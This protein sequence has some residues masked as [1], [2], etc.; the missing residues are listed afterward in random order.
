MTGCPTQT[1][2]LSH[3]TNTV[4]KESSPK[5]SNDENFQFFNITEHKTIKSEDLQDRIANEKIVE[6]TEE[7]TTHFGNIETYMSETQTTIEAE[8]L[9]IQ[10]LLKLEIE[11]SKQLLRILKA[12]A[13][14]KFVQPNSG[15]MLLIGKAGVSE[16]ETRLKNLERLTKAA[17]TVKKSFASQQNDFF[18]AMA[19]IREL[20]TQ[21]ES[22]KE[23][24][25]RQALKLTNK[26]F[27]ASRR[28]KIRRRREAIGLELE[29]DYLN[30]FE[31]RC[32]ELKSEVAEKLP[33]MESV[34]KDFLNRLKRFVTES[35]NSHA[36]IVLKGDVI[37]K[38]RCKRVEI[39]K[40]S[41]SQL[42]GKDGVP[43]R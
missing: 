23:K 32:F 31:D 24:I 2:E 25:N 7:K 40:V 14:D 17:G 35:L 21:I 5:I 13:E 41:H 27:E 29:I 9:F 43:I 22:R 19:K 26:F 28:E 10:K 12:T 18:A 20:Q 16:Q 34:Y 30:D 42:F 39:L 37:N 15:A 6:K 38:R 11:H 3:S 36:K 8:L 33:R 4:A 1:M